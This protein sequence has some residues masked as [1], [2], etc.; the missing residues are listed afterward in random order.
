M[1]I[2]ILEDHVYKVTEKQFKAIK[3][4]EASLEDD[5]SFEGKMDD[6]LEN[7]RKDYRFLG[8]VNFDFRI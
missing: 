8:R 2:I 6:F 1:R 5:N 7:N 4:F 3:T